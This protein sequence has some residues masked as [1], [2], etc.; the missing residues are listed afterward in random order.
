MEK[1]RGFFIPIYSVLLLILFFPSRGL[2][3]N[4]PDYWTCKSSGLENV[5]SITPYKTSGYYAALSIYSQKD[6]PSNLWIGT[7][8]GV[9]STV[10]GGDNWN[11]Y[12]QGLLGERAWVVTGAPDHPSYIV[13]SN[14]RS[15]GDN[16]WAFKG[17][18]NDSQILFPPP[19]GAVKSIF[20]L[21]GEPLAL[22]AAF[23]NNEVQYFAMENGSYN[24]AR[25]K[26]VTA[27][28]SYGVQKLVGTPNNLA[29][30]AIKGN[31]IYLGYL[32]QW[33]TLKEG[34]TN[35]TIL[36]LAVN[37]NDYNILY[38]TVWDPQGP[39]SGVWG[40]PDGGHTWWPINNGL[41]VPN[42]T[43]P[44]QSQKPMIRKLLIDP[45][46]PNRIFAGVSVGGGGSIYQS[47]DKGA[48]WYLRAL[49]TEGSECAGNIYDM[50]FGGAQNQK[51]FI[52][53]E[54]GVATLDL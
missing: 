7:P 28:D 40:S 34:R 11:Y 43:N 30:Y 14:E 17:S 16:I 6:N 18:A 9:F 19:A 3:Q 29:V 12:N 48:H 35:A 23:E 39:Y 36:D 52:G 27:F 49:P 50:T 4:N 5:I 33:F 47:D 31:T 54:S 24:Q 20:V 2:S 8:K 26:P 21:K 25:W 41:P 13:A 45:Q 53:L 10:N 42:T 51:L 46:N 37:P 44:L 38:V 22:L 15:G 1:H 32:G